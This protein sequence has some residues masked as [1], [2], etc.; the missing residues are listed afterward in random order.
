MNS[1]QRCAGCR[2]HRVVSLA[3]ALAQ[4]LAPVHTA[5][6]HASV[7]AMLVGTGNGGCNT[8]T[9]ALNPHHLC[10]CLRE[11]RRSTLDILKAATART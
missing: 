2:H 8:P 6:T 5:R 4:V 11:G 7:Q 10:R 1:P 9:L 3:Y